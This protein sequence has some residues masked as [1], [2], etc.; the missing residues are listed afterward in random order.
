MTYW[1][2]P[3]YWHIDTSSHYILKPLSHMEYW[4]LPFMTYWIPSLWH[5]DLPSSWYIDTSPLYDVYFVFNVH[6]PCDITCLSMF[7]HPVIYPSTFIHPVIYPSTFIHP[8]IYPSTFI[9]SVT[10]LSS[11]V[12]FLKLVW[13]V[14]KK[15]NAPPSPS[16]LGF[17]E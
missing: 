14:Y 6:T 10:C 12:V 2:L 9:H 8:V 16:P 17:P 1:H 11:K 5:W 15:L 4:H 13:Q 7:I 3:F